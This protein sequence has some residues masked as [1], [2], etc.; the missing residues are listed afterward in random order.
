ML[1]R[2]TCVWEGRVAS[3]CWGAGRREPKNWKLE[4]WARGK[5]GGRKRE[6]PTGQRGQRKGSLGD[7]IAFR[8][9]PAP[10]ATLSPPSSHPALGHWGAAPIPQHVGALLQRSERHRVSRVSHPP[11]C[12]DFRPNVESHRHGLSVIAGART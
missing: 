1:L 6:C 12:K 3:C 10:E 8:C 5:P 7:E 4:G 9:L 11:T 2:T